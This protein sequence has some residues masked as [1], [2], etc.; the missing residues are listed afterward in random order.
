MSLLPSDL[1]GVG[2]PIGSIESPASTALQV[3]EAH[4]LFYVVT[5]IVQGKAMPCTSNMSNFVIL[6]LLWD[7]MSSVL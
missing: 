7:P 3:I 1:F 2:N 5:V 6:C 4:R